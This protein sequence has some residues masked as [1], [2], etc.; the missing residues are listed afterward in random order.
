MV[1]SGDLSGKGVVY[2]DE[3]KLIQRPNERI[4]HSSLEHNIYAKRLA[5]RQKHPRIFEPSK[6]EGFLYITDQRIVFIRKP[7]PWRAA[8]LDLTPVGISEALPK[9]MAAKD[10][11]ALKAC[12]YIEVPYSEIV[13]FRVKRGRYATIIAEDSMQ[14]LLV[15]IY[16]K[17]RVDNKLDLLEQALPKTRDT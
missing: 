16:R 7:D 12:R 8:W 3:G 13:S 4:L 5:P 11:K 14:R 1:K 10:L 15:E 2:D 9:A 6:E 17:N